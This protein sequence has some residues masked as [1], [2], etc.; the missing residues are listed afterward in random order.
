MGKER[1]VSKEVKSACRIGVRRG[2]NGFGFITA[3]TAEEP[4]MQG[5]LAERHAAS[6]EARYLGWGPDSNRE[7]RAPLAA[8]PQQGGER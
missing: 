4:G 2:P 8:G 6:L 7:L 3:M 1:E 5:D